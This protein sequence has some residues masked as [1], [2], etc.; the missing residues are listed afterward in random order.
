MTDQMLRAARSVTANIAKG[1]GRFHYQENP[2]FCRQARG[3]LD[4]VLD[5]FIAG[6]EERLI[7]QEQYKQLRVLFDRAVQVL[8]GY[9]HCLDRA[10]KSARQGQKHARAD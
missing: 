3:S 6:R 4:E 9:I 10:A 2:Q 1:Y 7:D 8:N 5:H